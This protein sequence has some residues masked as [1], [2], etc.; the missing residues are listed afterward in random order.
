MS[1]SG[2]RVAGVE[3]E[4]AL[5]SSPDRGV[6][7]ESQRGRAATGN[8]RIT[9]APSPLQCSSL[10]PSSRPSTSTSPRQITY[11]TPST[12]H[13][14]S[15]RTTKLF[16]ARPLQASV[17]GGPFDSQ[18]QRTWLANALGPATAVTAVPA[19]ETTAV[20]HRFELGEVPEEICR[21]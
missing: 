6:A 12:S 14:A 21:R 20:C 17:S 11:P 4:L 3:A 5:G 18:H 16:P 2:G 7:A 1:L 19:N 15:Y 13:A 9:A 8:F 10:Q